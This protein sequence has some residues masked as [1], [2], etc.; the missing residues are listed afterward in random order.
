[1]CSIGNKKFENIFIHN[2]ITFLGEHSNFNNVINA[3]LCLCSCFYVPVGIRGKLLL[4]F[5]RIFL[6]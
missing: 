2:L 3:L 5:Y 1:M 6:D 4:R